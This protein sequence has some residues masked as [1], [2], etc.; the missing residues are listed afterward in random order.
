MIK[1]IWLNQQIN[2]SKKLN[3]TQNEF[4]EINFSH[5]PFSQKHMYWSKDS[6]FAKDYGSLGSIS[7]WEK[8]KCWYECKWHKLKRFLLIRT[9]FKSLWEINSFYSNLIKHWL[10]YISSPFLVYGST[11]FYNSISR[12]LSQFFSIKISLW[13][14]YWVGILKW[15]SISLTVFSIL[16]FLL[17]T[18]LNKSDWFVVL[19]LFSNNKKN[20]FLMEF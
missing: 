1:S 2:N 6:K 20:L 3:W 18:F 19:P 15:V 16:Y 12:S 14:N 13:T 5:T 11:D 4:I 10:N 7:S 17:L 9:S 8:S